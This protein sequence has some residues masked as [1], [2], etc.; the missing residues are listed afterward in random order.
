MIK[1]LMEVGY[2][3]LILKTTR[4]NMVFVMGK[5]KFLL[6][7]L[8]TPDILYKCEV[9]GYNIS[10]EFWKKKEKIHKLFIIYNINIKRNKTP[11]IILLLEGGL[12]PFESISLIRYLK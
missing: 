9:W 1:G 4:I 3:I 6:G 11:Y 8:A 7:K 5:N 2:L 10:L 12:P